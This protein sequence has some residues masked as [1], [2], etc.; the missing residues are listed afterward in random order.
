MIR[1]PNP[2]RGLDNPREV[3]AWGMYDFANQS[4]TLLI[5]TLL[6]SLYFKEVVVAEPLVASGVAESTARARG[7]LAWALTHSGSM[8]L[9]VI[10][11][12]LLG[13][14]AD[15][16]QWRKELLILTGISCVVLTCSLG[17]VGPGWILLGVLLYIPANVSYQIGENF[18]ASFLPDVSTPRN[19]GRVSAIG[20]TMGYVGAL[21]LL[22][23]VLGS[24]LLFGMK[25][26]ADWRPFFVFAGLWFALGM[27][28]AALF[29]REKKR[30]SARCEN[31]FRA[32]VRRLR[33][34]LRHASRHRQLIRFL[35]AFFIYGLGVHVIISFASIIATDFGM[36]ETQLAI[37]TLQLTL[38]AGIAAATTSFFQDRIGARSTV[39]LYLCIWIASAS[40]MLVLTL[41]PSKP[42]WLFWVIGNGIGLGLGG[43]GTSSR[44]MV[45]RF[46][47]RHRS[48]EFFGLWGL[49]YKLAAAV[50]VLS[51]GVVKSALG[52]TGAMILLSS[53]FV[54]GCVL[55]LRVNELAGVREARR[56]ERIANA[57]ESA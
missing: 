24:M 33:E 50:G 19:I 43:I 41:I 18:L 9:V 17:L 3:W 15:A 22:I 30:E 23:L 51:F 39:L 46:T 44:S 56:A 45:G 5:I 32:S 29:V 57:G 38:T 27:V 10:L 2:F 53:F 37:F 55:M 12:P 21:A 35:T 8:L 49:T 14:L 11:S 36:N 31:P 47:P 42:Q 28:P 16:R 26:K 6:F 13:A 7:D 48:A 52:N 1:T 20:W 34:T 40:A 54:I 4:F 25:A